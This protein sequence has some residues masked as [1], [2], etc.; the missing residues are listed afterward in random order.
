MKK[1]KTSDIQ[2]VITVAL[3]KEIPEDWLTSRHVAVHTLA[4]LNSG[5]LSQQCV[6]QSGIVIVI[7]GTGINASE[8]AACWICDNLAPLFVLNIG[9]CGVKDKRHSPGKWISPGYVANEDGDL[10]ELDTRLPVPDHEKVINVNSLL[11]VKKAVT[12]N[13]PASWKKHDV[14][15]MECFSQARVFSK[16][17]ISFHCLKFGTDYSDSNIHMDFN[18]NLEL[19]RQETKKLFGFLEPDSNRIK[20]TAVVPAYNRERT[21]KRGIDSILSQSH[22]PEEIIVVDDCS[23][24]RT[25]EVLEGYGDKIIR[26]YLP[27]N[28]GPSKARNEGIRH[29]GS[30]WIAFMDSDDC[31]KKDKL[32][33]QVDYLKKYPFYQILQSDEIWIR[34]GVRV[35]PCR[36]HTKPA[37]WIWEPSLERCLVSPSGVL[38]KKSLIEQYGGFDERLPVCEDY[39]LW[40]K[41]S[42]DHPVGLEPGLSVIKY[43]GHKDQLSRKYPAMDRFRVQSLTNILKNENKPYFRKKIISTLT[44]K[45]N[46]L[47]KGYEKRRKLKEAQECREIL[48]A[49]NT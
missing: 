11:S 7:T 48:R 16:A 20:V 31:W 39:D 5:A 42:R 45:L 15:D 32:Q 24:D 17:D 25:R 41:I 36:H 9:T 38:I 23:T 19:F 10:L 21:V 34:N 26:V 29:A 40:L 1:M 28:S 4:A 22:M 47:I 3:K 27:Q 33:N 35:N 8:E 43:G 12:G 14:F 18:R 37:G 49:L 44:K 30:G 13:I 6:S 2:L 46:I